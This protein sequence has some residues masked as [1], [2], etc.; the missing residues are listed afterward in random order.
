M[1]YPSPIGDK[2]FLQRKAPEQTKYVTVK[3]IVE[4]GLTSELAGYMREKEMKLK[5]QPGELFTRVGTSKV[6]KY[7]ESLNPKSVERLPDGGYANPI[8]E[9]RTGSHENTLEDIMLLDCRPV[10]DF[11]ACHIQ[12]AIHYPKVRL[13]HATYPFLNEMFSYRNKDNKLIVVY[14]LDES[15]AVEVTNAV[16]Q[17]GINNIAM[18]A[19]GLQEFVQDYKSLITGESPVPIVP[20]DARMQRRADEVTQARSEARSHISQRPKSLSNSLSKPKPPRRF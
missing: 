12:G 6:A 5:R 16:Y 20:R 17:R 13:N 18:M 3:P 2:D 7:V 9:Y 8:D 1:S 11:N 15:I 19:G 10:E 4:T 14:D